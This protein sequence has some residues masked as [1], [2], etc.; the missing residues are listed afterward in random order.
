M[1]DGEFI[2]EIASDDLQL[3]NRDLYAVQVRF[4]W[5][6]DHWNQLSGVRGK[7]T[8][9]VM[10]VWRWFVKYV[11]KNPVAQAD[12]DGFAVKVGVDVFFS[13]RHVDEAGD[14]TAD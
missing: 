12:G 9:V 8:S 3:F 7:S 11:V 1:F 14:D 10:D 4:V 2:D 6:S 13:G 5:F